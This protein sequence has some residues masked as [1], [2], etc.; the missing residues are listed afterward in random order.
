MWIKKHGEQQHLVSKH[1]SC[2]HVKQR[3]IV[4]GVTRAGS[5]L[6]DPLAGLLWLLSSDLLPFYGGTYHKEQQHLVTWKGRTINFW[7][8]PNERNTPLPPIQHLLPSILIHTHHQHLVTMPMPMSPPLRP[9]VTLVHAATDGQR[10]R[11]LAH[12]CPYCHWKLPLQT[13]RSC[14]FSNWPPTIHQTSSGMIQLL[15]SGTSLLLQL[16]SG[17]LWT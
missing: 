4:L 14:L 3:G 17:Y 15:W 13:T 12:P 5:M 8:W 9:I 11:L 1:L 6:N 10:C 7:Y 16:T 2:I